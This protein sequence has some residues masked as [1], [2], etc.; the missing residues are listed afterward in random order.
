MLLKQPIQ[1]RLDDRQMA[2][3]ADLHVGHF[4]PLRVMT[5]QVRSTDG[6]A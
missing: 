1:N 2:D 5:F 4:F 6:V 3:N